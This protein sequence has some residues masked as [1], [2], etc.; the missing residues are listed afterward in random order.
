MYSQREIYYPRQEHYAPT[1]RPIQAYG[2]SEAPHY[3]APYSAQL[4]TTLS[5][6]QQTRQ[7]YRNPPITASDP[8]AMMSCEPVDQGEELLDRLEQTGRVPSKDKFRRMA[9]MVNTTFS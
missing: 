7:Y 3:Y 8:Y 1:D 9:C 4:P 5:P 2:E 6:Q